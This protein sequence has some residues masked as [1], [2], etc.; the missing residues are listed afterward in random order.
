[1]KRRR[2]QRSRSGDC[3]CVIARLRVRLVV[4][5]TENANESDVV[6]CYGS[7]SGEAM[8]GEVEDETR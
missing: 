1:M 5:V 2:V 8:K 3:C 6:T 4:F 7:G